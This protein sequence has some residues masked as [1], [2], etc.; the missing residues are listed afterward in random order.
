[1]FHFETQTIFSTLSGN[2]TTTFLVVT[3]PIY[4]LKTR[5]QQSKDL[6]ETII[7]CGNEA[8]LHNYAKDYTIDLMNYECSQDITIVKTGNDEAFISLSYIKTAS[9]T[10]DRTF[11]QGELVN[12]FFSFLIFGVLFIMLLFQ[13]FGGIKYN[14]Q[15]N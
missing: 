7:Y 5:T 3:E 1:M 6:S 9:T 13:K 8:I 15:K 12:T 11:S 10:I 2:T 4:I 14:A